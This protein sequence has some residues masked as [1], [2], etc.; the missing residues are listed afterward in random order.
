MAHKPAQAASDLFDSA[1]P[2]QARGSARKQASK[3]SGTTLPADW[4]PS[5][6]DEA[7]GIDLGLT[8]QQIWDCAEDMRLWA[9]GNANRAVARKADWS[10]TFK[11]WMRAKSKSAATAT[12]TATTIR[13]G[14]AM[15]SPSSTTISNEPMTRPEAIRLVK[16]LLNGF[17]NVNLTNPEGYMAALATVFAEYPLWADEEAVHRGGGS[18]N[19]DFPP[20]APALRNLLEGL[21]FRAE[22]ESIRDSR[23]DPDPWSLPSLE[24]LEQERERLERE[25][26]EAAARADRY[27]EERWRRFKEESR[28]RREFA[29]ASPKHRITLHAGESLVNDSKIRH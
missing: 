1:E 29:E 25:R 27:E 24:M 4:A 14:C 9:F 15:P 23:P 17:P 7:Y 11:G 20:S 8:R 19:L 16:Q 21:V 6:A 22:L 28:K 18:R 13:K 3:S 26:D 5:Q 12:V 10:A 2:K